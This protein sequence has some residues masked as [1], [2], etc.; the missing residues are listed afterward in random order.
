MLNKVKKSI[1]NG[2]SIIIFPEGT[3]KLPKESPNYKSGIAGIYK[4]SKSKVL[5]VAVNSGFYWPK[6]S[7]IKKPGTIK[8]KFLKLIDSE[9]SKSV[10]LEIIESVDMMRV[11]EHGLKV[12]MVQTTFRTFPVDTKEDLKKVE[13]IM[14]A[15]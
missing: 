1:Y 4:E 13:E 8:I 10:F 5:P 14:R 15:E 7:F 6:H 11:I 3:R 2:N 12:K 9:L